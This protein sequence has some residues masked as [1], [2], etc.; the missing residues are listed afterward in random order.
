MDQFIESLSGIGILFIIGCSALAIYMILYFFRMSNDIRKIKESANNL[1][2]GNSIAILK[3]M[4]GDKE[5]AI[6][7]IRETFIHDCTAMFERFYLEGNTDAEGYKI[8]DKYVWR[9]RNILPEINKEYLK[10]IYESVEKVFV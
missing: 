3:F 10:E 7:L 5:G 9:Y 8:I 4:D 2:T 6:R 1:P